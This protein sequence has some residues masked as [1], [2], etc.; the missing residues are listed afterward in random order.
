MSD[1]TTP[2][3][4]PINLIGGSVGVFVHWFDWAAY[5]YLAGTIADVFFP[6]DNHVAG[7]LAA[8]AVFAVSFA[9]RPLGALIFGPL[10]DRIGR[11]RSLVLVVTIM[12]AATLVVGLLPGYST[13]GIA[14][15]IL[16]ISA[17]L[18]QGLAAGGEFGSAATFLAEHAPRKS[19]GFCVSGLEVGSLLGFLAA[20]LV[21]FV[22]D[23]TLTTDQLETWGWR[24]PFLAAAPLGIAAYL[25]RRCTEDT[26]AF[27]ELE[28]TSQKSKAPLTELVADRSTR[29]TL[30]RMFGIEIMQHVSFY[31]VLVY[32]VTYQTEQLGFDAGKAAL[33]STLASLAGCLLVP[34]FGHL[35]DRVGRKPILLAAGVGMVI[36][37]FPLFVW[38]KQGGTAG[39][40]AAT[41]L[42]GVL[43]A[44]VLAVH[45]TTFA[46]LF[47][48][49]VR[50][51]GLS[52]GYSLTAAIFAGTTPFLMTWLSSLTSWGLIPAAYLALVGLV[53][54]LTTFTMRESV[55]ADLDAVTT[56][57][58]IT[59][60]VRET[61]DPA[62]RDSSITVRE[63]SR[64]AANTK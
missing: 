63:D 51:A 47:P 54:V 10:G 20:S 36:A 14:A 1:T 44:A 41:V 6:S 7:V 42:L 60:A 49:P 64:A 13:I 4:R 5:A 48:T 23:T 56:D 38:M 22:L 62:V 28:E 61:S 52:V 26:P 29:L 11:Q 37:A 24:I 16:L 40:I 43:V 9:V 19:R 34:A 2:R 17:R 33:A 50:Q 15:P 35:S 55:G 53:G 31:L 59:Q 30:F 32:L 3:I 27:L 25:I 21:V 18:L 8:L 12:S 58:I 45:A 46:E 57:T 39:M